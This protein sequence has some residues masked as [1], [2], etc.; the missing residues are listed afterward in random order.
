M[1]KNWKVGKL[2]SIYN[3]R[4]YPIMKV[5]DTG[6]FANNIAFKLIGGSLKDEALNVNYYNNIFLNL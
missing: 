5:I 6:F 3:V 2:K 4:N 1:T